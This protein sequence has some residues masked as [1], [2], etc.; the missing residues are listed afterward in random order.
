M[1]T[2][3]ELAKLQRSVAELTRAAR[4]LVDGKAPRTQIERSALKAEI[5]RCIQELDELRN[6]L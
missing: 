6:K 3:S 2:A 1:G 5:E 4:P